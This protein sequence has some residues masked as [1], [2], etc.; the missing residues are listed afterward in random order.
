M[1]YCLKFNHALN[2]FPMKKQ[3]TILLFTCALTQAS[4]QIPAHFAPIGTRWTYNYYLFGQEYGE[5]IYESKGDTLVNG[6]AHRI[7]QGTRTVKCDYSN[8]V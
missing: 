6:A 8:C 4:A 5:Y 3:F 7:I 1:E 2:L